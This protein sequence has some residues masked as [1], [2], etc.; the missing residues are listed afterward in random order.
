MSTQILYLK[1]FKPEGMNAKKSESGVGSQIVLSSSKTI[2]TRSI[3]NSNIEMDIIAKIKEIV[4]N[5]PASKLKTNDFILRFLLF[6]ILESSS[7]ETP[8]FLN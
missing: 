1:T 5:I 4:M 3:F 2:G 7:S 6:T 8:H